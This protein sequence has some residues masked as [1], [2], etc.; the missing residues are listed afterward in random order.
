MQLRKER[1]A[2]EFGFFEVRSLMLAV[3]DRNKVQ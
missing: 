2:A 1:M 3:S